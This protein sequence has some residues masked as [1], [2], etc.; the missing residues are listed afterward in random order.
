MPGILVPILTRF[1]QKFGCRA[2][3][4]HKMAAQDSATQEQ[5]SFL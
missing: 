5:F 1:V 3:N 2:V 4:I